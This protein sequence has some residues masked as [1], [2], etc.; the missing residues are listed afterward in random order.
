MRTTV[1]SAIVSTLCGTMAAQVLP[2]PS[3]SNR[4]RVPHESIPDQMADGRSRPR[5]DSSR[6]DPI[7]KALEEPGLSN[8]V[9][10]GYVAH[11]KIL[12]S[13]PR[14]RLQWH[15]ANFKVPGAWPVTNF[16]MLVVNVDS[17]VEPTPSVP[18]SNLAKDWHFLTRNYV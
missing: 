6:R 5:V 13:H 14:F 16:A 9:E 15:L 18:A 1:L 7:L 11:A 3:D 10:L 2:R 17:G 4:G 12:S 8:F